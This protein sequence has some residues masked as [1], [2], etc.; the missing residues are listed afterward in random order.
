MLPPSMTCAHFFRTISRL[1]SNSNVRDPP[2]SPPPQ[3]S[4]PSHFPRLFVLPLRC[5]FFALSY[6]FAARLNTIWP[7]LCLRGGARKFFST[8]WILR[9]L[10]GAEAPRRAVEGPPLLTSEGYENCFS[11]LSTCCFKL[12][13]LSFCTFERAEHTH[14][15]IHAHIHNMQI[16]I[17]YTLTD[18]Q[19]HTDTQHKYT[20][21]HK[22]ATRGNTRKKETHIHKTHNQLK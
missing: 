22:Q 16:C 10:I 12:I 2:L 6:L 13:L 19:I 15:Q 14:A 3:S 18:T 9:A 1:S 21:K 4:Q 17:T 7:R 20:R 5:F 8:F 11:F